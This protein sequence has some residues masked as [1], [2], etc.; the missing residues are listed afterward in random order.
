M[1]LRHARRSDPRGR[2]KWSAQCADLLH[3]AD[4]EAA[5][6]HDPGPRGGHRQTGWPKRPLGAV[7][8][9]RQGDLCKAIEPSSTVKYEAGFSVQ[10]PAF[11]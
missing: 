2:C 1:S 6:E 5:N 10:Q 9:L 11:A 7:R 8:M 3:P 4:P